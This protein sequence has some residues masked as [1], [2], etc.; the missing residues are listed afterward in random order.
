MKS[1]DGHTLGIMMVCLCAGLLA[2][3]RVGCMLGWLLACHLRHHV[4][5]AGPRCSL[6]LLSLHTSSGRWPSF[7][8]T[9]QDL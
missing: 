7:A 9:K 6:G 4:V 1:L 8:G 2:R 3:L 5:A